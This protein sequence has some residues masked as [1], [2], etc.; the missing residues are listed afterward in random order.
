MQVEVVANDKGA[1]HIRVE[2]LLDEQAAQGVRNRQNALRT[3]DL[4]RAGWAVRDFEPADG[5]GLRASA[6]H[7]F[8]TPGEANALFDQLTG[9][10]G[11][12][13]SLVLARTRGLLNTK[14]TLTGN[15]DLTKGLSA[16]GDEELRS[17]TGATSLVGVDD[18]VVERQA[19][20]P[21]AEAFRL[22]LRTKIDGETATK[23]LPLGTSTPII[24]SRTR[25]AIEALAFGLAGLSA[26]IWLA[27]L[28]RRRSEP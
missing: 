17:L 12:F 24:V 21:I 25:G 28:W 2:L 16:F 6:E 3:K 18:V 26:L 9:P 5:G 11:P 23:A 7:S 27:L 1:G 15:V 19:G 13:G 8:A 14:V 10:T 4:S 20:K 22:E